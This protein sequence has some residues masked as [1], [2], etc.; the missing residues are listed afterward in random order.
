MSTNLYTEV[1]NTGGYLDHHE[2]DLYIEVNDVNKA[3][4]AKYP[5]E[6][7]NKTTFRNAVTGKLCWDIP[8]AYMPY[9][10]KKA[11]TRNK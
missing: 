3:I 11:L 2:S 8:F 1:L 5:I 9:W 10:S 7:A 4:L 6:N